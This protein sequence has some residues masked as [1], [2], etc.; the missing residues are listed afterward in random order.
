V[1]R[2]KNVTPATVF[3]VAV[4]AAL[5]HYD[6]PQWLG[7]RSPLASPYFLSA[8][9]P[10]GTAVM[11]LRERGL[12][13]QGVLGEAATSLWDGPL[14]QTRAALINAVEEDRARLGNKSPRYYY[15][16]LE[17][18]YLRRHFP[19][20]A[21]PAAVEAMPGYVNVSP[22][23]FFIHLEEA[24][25]EL[26]RR[27]L[28]RLTPALRLERPDLVAPP[29]G[30]SAVI[31]LAL[32]ELLAGRSV[33]LTGVGGVGKSTVG[34]ALLA[35]WP[36][37]AVF[38]HSFRP[39]LN[40]DLNSLLFSL[41]H[42][43]HVAGAPALWAQLLAGEGRI[44]P[45]AQALGFL[46]MDLEAI[47]ARRPLLCFDEVDLL[48]T[49]T[50]DPRRKQHIQVLELLESL[51]GVAP[52]L[53]IGQR[54]YVDVDV[55]CP[56]EPLP[57]GEAGELL[58]RLGLEPDAPTLRRVHHF[59]G[60][61]PRL[62][63]LYAA[64]RRSGDAGDDVLSLPREPS[65]QPLFSRL[66][67]RLDGEERE[68]LSALSVFRSF[69][70][71]DAWAERDA[72]LGSLIDRRLV[73]TD[74]AGGI[75]LLS[76]FRDLVHDALPPEQRR[77]LQGEAAFIRAQ[78][79]DYTAAAYHYWQ[80]DDSDAAVQVWFAHQDGEILAGQAGA[81]D[82]VFQQ[83]EPARLDDIRRGEL[84]VIRNR[85]ALL[86]GEA[87]RV[88]EGMEGFHWEVDDETTAKAVG[89][90]GYANELLGQ[91]EQAQRHF[92]QAIAM[93]SRAISEIAT[94]HLRR[95]LLYTEQVD[96][97]AAR[98]E[99]QLA[100]TDI[101]RLQ[102]VIDY[103]AGLFEPAQAHFKSSL[104]HAE[105]A[106][107]R[108]RI[109]K[110]HYMLAMLAGRQGRVDDARAHAETAMSHF[111]AIGDRL[112]L[113]GMRA[114][115]AGMYLNVRQFE[116]VIEPAERALAFFERIKH[117]RWI[118]AICNNL[119]EAYLETGQLEQARQYAMRVL[120]LEIPRS[121][122][123]ALYTLGHVHDREGHS[124]YAEVSFNEGIAVAQT[125]D[126]RFIQAYLERALG[127]LLAR[128]EPPADGVVHL[129]AALKLFA[130]M[131]LQHEVTET[132]TALQAA[133]PS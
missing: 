22:T 117:Q 76:F 71:R 16:L 97:Q 52:L 93:L 99:T 121:R 124:A 122:P 37:R 20:S 57:P 18:R 110:A 63:E 38:W 95:G 119:A 120:Q 73:K 98:R 61:N 85:L 104:R 102:G 132:E 58:R 34:A 131:G 32:R 27:V 30:R 13:L 36:S 112:Q 78:R 115:L 72:A 40:D 42:F 60:G 88:L 65:A 48:H 83:I 118:S 35:D 66:W 55:H 79:G 43:A 90:W 101:E 11:G 17:L 69:A 15:L 129:E 29:I 12:L 82:E 26:G 128:A 62:L 24:I 105:A 114:E 68:L 53:L 64:L 84:Q 92:D 45:P 51:R 39:G 94:W 10:G 116:A 106:T 23:R 59:T 125:N 5:E 126:D 108:D 123:Y 111:A 21:F 103:M 54:V 74:A 87:D 28:E 31:E 4:R 75:G 9:Q 86:A 127:A 67:R 3:L 25:D 1:A 50:G 96:L 44:G 47:A 91:S 80:A 130:E 8:Q 33:A 41:G 109:A 14:P 89:Q 77:R 46:H 2:Q 113:E 6:D 7:R 81:A 133:R 19:P 49:S 100:T 70:P 107:D 56:L